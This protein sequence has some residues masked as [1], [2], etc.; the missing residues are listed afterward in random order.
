MFWENYV[1]LCSKKGVAPNAV[2]AKLGKSSGSV[3]AWKNGTVPRETT[4]KKIADYFEVS[5][6]ALLYGQK[7]KSPAPEGAELSDLEYILSRLPYM[8]KEDIAKL[9]AELPQIFMEK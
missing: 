9:M 8:S 4:L 5:V 1:A 2:A 6:D 3:T 7:E